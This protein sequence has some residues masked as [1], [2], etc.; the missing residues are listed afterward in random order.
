MYFFHYSKINKNISTILITPAKIVVFTRTMK[1]IAGKMVLNDL[2]MQRLTNHTQELIKSNFTK[3]IVDKTDLLEKSVDYMTNPALGEN[4]TKQTL[5]KGLFP[6][7]SYTKGTME[8][9]L[10]NVAKK[11][12]KVKIENLKEKTDIRWVCE[13]TTADRFAET[14]E[15]IQEIQ[16]NSEKPNKETMTAIIS[17]AQTGQTTA[18]TTVK[19]NINNVSTEVFRDIKSGNNAKDPFSG[20]LAEIPNTTQG[21]PYSI[22]NEPISFNEIQAKRS[23]I[24]DSL[25]KYNEEFQNLQDKFKT[26]KDLSI[27]DFDKNRI[28]QEILFQYVSKHE[29]LL[30]ASFYYNYSV[31]ETTTINEIFYDK[32]KP[33]INNTIFDN[34]KNYNQFMKIAIKIYCDTIHDI[35]QNIQKGKAFW[36]G[37]GFEEIADDIFK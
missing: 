20:V 15:L 37:T 11:S 24:I 13:K 25:A 35:S 21:N 33:H 9:A 29:R 18:D 19:F 34:K 10:N 2:Q 5:T 7:I 22:I 17:K 36:M 31:K 14:S 16:M 1:R 12:S 4:I 3:P 6:R 26:A 32:L 23:I 28:I 30:K 27:S 8:T